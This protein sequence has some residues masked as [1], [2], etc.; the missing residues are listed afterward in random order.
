[1][2][3]AYLIY[4]LTG[5]RHSEVLGLR[6]QAIDFAARTLEVSHTIVYTNGARLAC[7]QT[8]SKTS[9][10][11]FRISTELVD[12]LKARHDAQRLERAAGSEW[13]EG[14]YVF[15]SWQGTP[16][17]ESTLRAHRDRMVQRAEVPRLT[18]HELR[19]THASLA[20]L[21]GV[22]IK[23]ISRRLG[24][25]SV[26][27]T[28]GIYQHLYTEQEDAGAL[29]TDGSVGRKNKRVRI[30]PAVNLPSNPQKSRQNNQDA[31]RKKSVLNGGAEDGT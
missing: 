24:H 16:V 28:W 27:T 21:T 10:R 12:A 31:L 13:Q 9:Q 1:L 5:L 22:D 29:T 17:S 15:T 4:L 8:K 19:H 6:W 7:D 3:A 26:Q 23:E 18:F 30:S 2:Y 20:K 11:K 25:A 14:D